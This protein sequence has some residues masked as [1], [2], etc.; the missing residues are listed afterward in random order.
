MDLLFVWAWVEESAQQDVQSPS[1]T[2]IPGARAVLGGKRGVSCES[3]ADRSGAGPLGQVTYPGNDGVQCPRPSCRPVFRWILQWLP[4][5]A[6]ASGG[7]PFRP[8]MR[9][10]WKNRDRAWCGPYEFATRSGQKISVLAV[11]GRRPSTLHCRRHYAPISRVA[12]PNAPGQPSAP[13]RD[14]SQQR[15]RPVHVSHYVRASAQARDRRRPCPH[16]LGPSP[17]PR[18]GKPTPFRSF[19]APLAASGG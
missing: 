9:P 14:L 12:Y 6:L 11:V 15:A 5:H 3:H 13:S 17:S 8:N 18:S 7:L 4:D 1:E 16:P 19:P 10:P 2:E